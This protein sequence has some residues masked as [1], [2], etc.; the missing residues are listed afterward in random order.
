MKYL[1]D[2]QVIEYLRTI[3]A[4]ERKLNAEIERR[5]LADSRFPAPI[6]Q[7]AGDIYRGYVKMK[8]VDD[9]LDDLKQIAQ[10]CLDEM[11]ELLNELNL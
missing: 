6:A 10:K 11:D 7:A 8:M 2:D 3:V 4:V 1:T 9:E 5:A